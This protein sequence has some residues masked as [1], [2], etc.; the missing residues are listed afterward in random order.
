MQSN[1]IIVEQVLIFGVL[2][3][4]RKLKLGVILATNYGQFINQSIN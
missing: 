1:S 3:E 4:L 2:L